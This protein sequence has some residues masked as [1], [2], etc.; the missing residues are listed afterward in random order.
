MENFI[1]SVKFDE[2]GLV[3]AIAQDYETNEV[4]MVAYMNAESLKMTLDSGI[5]TYWSRSR[6]KLW[7]KGESSGH[8][9]LVKEIRIDCD[10][11]A[12]VFLV[13]Q[14]GAACH[15]GYRSCFYRKWESDSW[16]IFC[17]KLF[18]PSKVYNK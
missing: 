18:D 4:V 6:Q 14:K 17:E 2:K 15:K 16:K 9:Q 12:L 1:E 11:D 8:I 10:G 7:K 13:D 5:C 3:T